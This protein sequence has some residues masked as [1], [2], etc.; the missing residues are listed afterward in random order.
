MLAFLALVG[1]VLI[2]LALVLLFFL[3]LVCLVIAFLA[4]V[5]SVLVSVLLLVLLVFLFLVGTLHCCTSYNICT[6]LYQNIRK[7]CIEYL[8]AEGRYI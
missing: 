8:Y 1:L 7:V 3:P 2:F 5:L 6:T 4:L